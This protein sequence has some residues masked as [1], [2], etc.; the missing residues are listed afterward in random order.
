[1]GISIECESNEMYGRKRHHF[2]R[3]RKTECQNLSNSYFGAHIFL[4][5]KQTQKKT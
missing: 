4:L 2:E 3:Q 1:M 5:R